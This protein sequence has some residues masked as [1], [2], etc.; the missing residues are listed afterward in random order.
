MSR[1]DSGDSA[2]PE[3]ETEDGSAGFCVGSR[4]EGAEILRI[5]SKSAFRSRTIAVRA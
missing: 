4:D 2:A 1:F 5:I 3:G